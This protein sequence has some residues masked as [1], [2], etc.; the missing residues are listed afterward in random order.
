MRLEYRL[1]LS[2]IFLSVKFCNEINNSIFLV[3]CKKKASI[4]QVYLLS[5]HSICFLR[6][7]L[8]SVGFE[9]LISILGI[10]KE[11]FDHRG[12]TTVH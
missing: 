3:S 10:N 4:D 6:F 8:I 7:Y 1:L 5:L 9:Y 11:H 2:I 12:A